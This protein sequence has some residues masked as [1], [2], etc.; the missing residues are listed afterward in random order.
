MHL[1]HVAWMPRCPSTRTAPQT[2]I[3]C[4]QTGGSEVFRNTVNLAWK[5]KRQHAGCRVIQRCLSKEHRKEHG[6]NVSFELPARGHQNDRVAW[7]TGQK[8]EKKATCNQIRHRSKMEKSNINSHH[9]LL[10][11]HEFIKW[12]NSYSALLA[13][14]STGARQAASRASPHNHISGEGFA[15]WWVRRK[16]VAH[17]LQL[18][19][20][21][22]NR[23]WET[24]P[25][26][27][28]LKIGTMPERLEVCLQT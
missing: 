2:S 26:W 14:S 17:R 18:S 22:T 13:I 23:P 4:D 6:Q 12:H 27:V 10:K 15:C 7:G 19:S 28:A 3:A 16:A 9:I 1:Q 5:V 21:T 25:E 8:T 11:D 20:F 24:S